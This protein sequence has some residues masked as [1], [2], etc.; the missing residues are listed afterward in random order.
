MGWVPSITLYLA[1]I[2]DPSFKGSDAQLWPT[3]ST[4]SN[5]SLCIQANSNAHKIKWTILKVKVIVIA[6]F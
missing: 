2:P 6:I 1:I 4:G 3:S 5:P